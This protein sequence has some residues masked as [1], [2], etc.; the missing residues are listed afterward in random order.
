MNKVVMMLCIGFLIV[1]LIGI[2]IG[3]LMTVVI[4]H[5]FYNNLDIEASKGQ[6]LTDI[7]NET[8]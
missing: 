5:M 3:A 2:A 6:E 7:N 8:E 4:W 1:S